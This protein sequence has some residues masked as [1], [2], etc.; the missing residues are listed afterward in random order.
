M[1][2]SCCWGAAGDQLLFVEELLIRKLLLGN[3]C[4]EA[5]EGSCRWEAAERAVAKE[6]LMRSCWREAAL[7]D[8]LL[9]S[10]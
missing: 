3:C 5:A 8:L 10:C 9:G 6:L 2:I 4:W 7:G 1:E